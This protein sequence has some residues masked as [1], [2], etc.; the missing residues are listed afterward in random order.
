MLKGAFPKNPPFSRQWTHFLERR[1]EGM[2][3]LFLSSEPLW[4]AR[5]FSAQV[6]NDS[7][8]EEQELLQLQRGR[9]RENATTWHKK[10]VSYLVR[11]NRLQTCRVNKVGW[12]II[13]QEE[14]L[15]SDVGKTRSQINF[16]I[17]LAL[18]TRLVSYT[19]YLHIFFGA[20]WI[21]LCQKGHI[22][23]VSEML[24]L[25]SCRRKVFS[26]SF[27]ISSKQ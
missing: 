2:S 3:V 13:C 14:T 6:A 16:N 19:C 12:D 9:E 18:Y 21:S 26:S 17:P 23:G 4:K 15:G 20:S 10:S 27:P 22:I 25:K 11:K 24:Y 8:E 1:R 7:G 5:L